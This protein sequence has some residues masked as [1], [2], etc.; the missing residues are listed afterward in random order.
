[1]AVVKGE[2]MIF[3][4]SPLK[5]VVVGCLLAVFL[6]LAPGCD[7]STSSAPTGPTANLVVTFDPNPTFFVADGLW[8]YRVNVTETNGVGVHI[9]G[10]IR[11][12]Y[13]LADV[14]AAEDVSGELEFIEEFFHCGG[15]GNYLP[16]FGIRCSDRYTVDWK[17]SGWQTYTFYGVDDFGNE[18]TGEGRLDLL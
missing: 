17:N 6:S 13:S 9:Y 14:P 5:K 12:A 11:Q 4:N 7:N 1:M 10:W 3:L 15:E 16:A 2:R 8:R 18:V